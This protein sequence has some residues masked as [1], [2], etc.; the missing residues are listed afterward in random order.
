MP[1]V[2]ELLF[3]ALLPERL[4][5]RIYEIPQFFLKWECVLVH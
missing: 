4:K 5:L 1:V 2:K 3:A